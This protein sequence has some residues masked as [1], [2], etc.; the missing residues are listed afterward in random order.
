MRTSIIAILPLL[1]LLGSST[2][3]PAADITWKV[4][5]KS[6]LV[7]SAVTPEGEELVLPRI[8]LPGSVSAAQAEIDAL[9]NTRLLI[10]RLPD[11][12]PVEIQIA[13]NIS[14]SAFESIRQKNMF[15]N[16][17]VSPY[18][19]G[20]PESLF[21]LPQPMVLTIPVAGLNSLL[22]QSGFSRGDDITLAFDAGGTFTRNGITANNLTSG[23]VS[24]ISHLST[25][26]GST[27]DLL[28][29]PQNIQINTWGKIKL[30]FGGSQ[31]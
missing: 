1:F 3:S 13:L 7:Y 14:G 23:L 10:Q 17:S 26:V 21:S 25:I 2:E 11:S 19:D 4:F 5:L 12:R 8:V 30:L 29:L 22:S 15:L 9:E 6:Q 20:R 27:S 16:I 31:R 24:N 28:G 18:R